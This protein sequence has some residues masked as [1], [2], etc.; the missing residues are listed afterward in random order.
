MFF[1]YDVEVFGLMVCFGV[2]MLSAVYECVG[3]SNKDD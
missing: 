1:G 2:I 3:G